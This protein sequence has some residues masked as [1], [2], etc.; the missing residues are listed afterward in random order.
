M[1]DAAFFS[2]HNHC[3]RG[4]VV[5]M[6]LL[7][8]AQIASAERIALVFGN[9]R[10]AHAPQLNAPER[11]ARAVASALTAL[12]FRVVGPLLDQSKADME[13]A[14]STF[15]EQARGAAAAVVYFSGHG[16]EVGGINY[17]IPV[18]AK[19]QHE[20]QA[21][22]EAVPLEVV[23]NQVGGARD[24]GLVI[25]DACRDNP[26][27]N[28]MRLAEGRTKDWVGKGL[29]PVEPSGQ[30][31]VAYAAKGGTRA[32]E[33]NSPN[34]RYTTVLLNYLRNYR[35]EPLPLSNLFG[36]VREDVLAATSKAQEPWLYGA[37]GRKDIYLIDAPV[38]AQSPLTSPISTMRST[39][40]TA[41]TSITPD[42][43]LIEQL[44]ATAH[45]QM[46]NRRITAPESGNALSSY[47]QVLELEPSNPTAIEG[48][49]QI[50]NH[51]EDI[52]RTSF[53]E[54]HIDEALAYINRGLRAMPK[55]QVLLNLR[56]DVVLIKENLAK[57]ISTK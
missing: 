3:K 48:I 57:D 23:L 13:A 26:L 18:N 45:M 46:K 1:D 19:L 11:D 51:Y 22:L 29:K 39:T 2:W 9:G 14:L 55:S 43:R 32:L 53:Q 10:Y 25:L 12:G 41:P 49:Q 15:G 33:G 7:G 6:L 52:A 42:T 35:Q 34:S 5:L 56:R 16:M 8:I 31:Y 54:G 28:Q 50:A 36:A 27:A 21:M 30:V 40:P 44:L 4:L 17:L 38:A 37:F 47:Q 20:N 24:Y